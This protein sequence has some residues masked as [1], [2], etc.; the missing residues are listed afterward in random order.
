MA[1]MIAWNISV[2]TGTR[3]NWLKKCKNSGTRDRKYG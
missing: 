3:Y 2:I 1:M